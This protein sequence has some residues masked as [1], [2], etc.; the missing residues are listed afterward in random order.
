MTDQP[1]KP[2]KKKRRKKSGRL[3][4]LNRGRSAAR[5]AAVQALYEMELAGAGADAVLPD[6][7]AERWRSAGLEEGFPALVA[8]DPDLLAMIAR[9]AWERLD[10]L[11]GI[12]AGILERDLSLERLQAVMRAILRA[13]T[14]ELLALPAN[15]ARVIVADYMGVAE[16]FFDKGPEITLANALLDRLARVLRASEMGE[17]PADGEEG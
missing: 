9:G 12:L 15:P 8:A 16:A 5:L 4:A 14:F 6:F 13:G 3:T 17:T 11:D 10:D 1:A 2:R 7:L